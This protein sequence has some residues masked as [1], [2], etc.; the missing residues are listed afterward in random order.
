VALLLTPPRRAAALAG[1]PPGG[2]LGVVGAR[3]VVRGGRSVPAC[4]ARRTGKLLHYRLADNSKLGGGPVVVSDGRCFVNGGGVFDL[5]TGKHLGSVGGP[6]VFA[7]GSLCALVGGEL[8]AFDP[9]Q[10]G[11]TDGKG[12]SALK[13]PLTPTPW[14]TA[15][16]PRAEALA[17]EGDRLYVA[18]PGQVWAVS[19][20]PRPGAAP[21]WRATFEGRPVH[22]VAAGGRLFVST[23]EGRVY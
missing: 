14:A 6:A 5:A 8:R 3:L 21:P 7:G 22:L 20:P 16:A 10:I 13:S 4:Y 15:A 23:R 9:A 1:A 11:K 19:L 2:S 17:A 18:A 12:T